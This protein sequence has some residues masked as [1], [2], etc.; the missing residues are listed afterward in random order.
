MEEAG[1][2]RTSAPETKGRRKENITSY[3]II[4][5]CPLRLRVP[6]FRGRAA[7]ADRPLGLS[8]RK[9][10]VALEL[11]CFRGGPTGPSCSKKARE[12][13]PPAAWDSLDYGCQ[14]AQSTRAWPE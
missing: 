4:Y 2:A 13:R 3:Q 6:C 9:H 11:A 1:A 8:P 5:H 7:E 12:S 10:E 14:R